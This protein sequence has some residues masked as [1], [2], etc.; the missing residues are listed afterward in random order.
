M[1]DV[2]EQHGP[3][4]YT[5]S[6]HGNLRPLDPIVLSPALSTFCGAD[7]VLCPSVSRASLSTCL[8]VNV[9]LCRLCL[10]V[11]HASLSLVS[12]YLRR[13]SEAENQKSQYRLRPRHLCA[14]AP[15]C[16]EPLLRR[17]TTSPA[18][19]RYR[20]WMGPCGGGCLPR[21]CRRAPWLRLRPPAGH[22]TPRYCPHTSIRSRGL[23][24][25]WVQ[26]A[27]AASAAT[28]PQ[29]SQSQRRQHRHP[30]AAAAEALAWAPRMSL[31]P[32]TT[33]RAHERMM[34]SPR[35]RSTSSHQQRTMAAPPC[36]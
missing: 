28:L 27:A 10:S 11:A 32:E 18:R 29:T 17:Q 25:R 7:S 21:R 36:P 26:H 35:Q 15:R 31:H 24:Q 22:S 6:Y 14:R 3:D 34:T 5:G 20:R 4:L 12:L 8:S 33:T 23:A 30:K 19:H 9:L 13:T 1:Q 2:I 16:A